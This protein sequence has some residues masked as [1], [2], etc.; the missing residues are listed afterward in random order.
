MKLRFNIALIFLWFSLAGYASTAIA[1]NNEPYDTAVANTLRP[2]ADLFTPAQTPDALQ[3]LLA[4]AK[5]A[6]KPVL[7]DFYAAWCGI[8]SEMDST[9]FSDQSIQKLLQAFQ[10]IRVDITRDTPELKQLQE[11]Y[12]V[13]ATPTIVFYGRNGKEFEHRMVGES[14]VQEFQEILRSLK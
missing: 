6:K 9:I 1:V 7:I 5:T 3:K 12:K 11:R 4:Q 2:A 13:H 10:V 8:C 14:T